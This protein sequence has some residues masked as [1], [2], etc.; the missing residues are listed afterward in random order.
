MQKRILSLCLLALLSLEVLAQE[1][2]EEEK[3]VVID[4]TEVIASEA[5]FFRI[6]KV[7]EGF[8]VPWSMEFLPDGD[9]LISDRRTGLLTRLDINSGSMVNVTGLPAMLKDKKIASGLFD[10]R[11][12]PDFNRNGW[13]Y[14]VT[15]VGEVDANGLAVTRMQLQGNKLFKAK[16]LLETRPRIDG[17]WHFGGRLV[18]AGRHLYLTTGEGYKHSHLAQDLSAHA[19]KVLRIL[20]DGRVP[21]DNPFVGREGALPEIWSYGIRS[22]QGLAK[23][24]DSGEI[25]L[26][27][28]GPQGGDEVNIAGRGLNYGWP[29]ITYGEEY[30]GGPVGEGKTHKAGLQQ[31]VYYW[32]PS[33]APSGMGF[34]RGKAFPGWNSSVFN[35]ALAL[36]HI[37]RLVIEEGRVLHEERLLEDREWRIRFVRSG[38]DGYL[39]F[40][41]D[42]GLILRLVPAP[43][44]PKKKEEGEA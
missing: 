20:D 19:G 21:E 42:K 36:K 41:I 30:G 11:V 5:A 22:P 2:E 3:P 26:N 18:L 43:R 15:G 28:H 35:G 32:R 40:G 38:P 39:Y 25:W 24:P 7:A 13:V 14:I 34:Y 31:P 4:E 9:A 27:E 16:T 6:E 37:N 12:H 17:K 8:E 44:P 1:T 10:V 33:I 29:E 23:H